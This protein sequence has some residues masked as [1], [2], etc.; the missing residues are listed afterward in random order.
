[1]LDYSYKACAYGVTNK[2]VEMVINGSGVRNTAWVLKTN[3]NTVVN[4]LKNGKPAHAS[5]NLSFRLNQPSVV[6]N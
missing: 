3:K 1:M 2:I 4:T 6:L 5:G